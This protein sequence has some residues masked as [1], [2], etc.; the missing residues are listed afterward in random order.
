M[1]KILLI[2]LISCASISFAEAP[3]TND[4]AI[5]NVSEL[6]KTSVETLGV[7]LIALSYLINSDYQ[8]YMP[9]KYYKDKMKYYEELEKAGYISIEYVE[10][11]F[12][13]SPDPQ[14]MFQAIPTIKGG[15]IKVELNAP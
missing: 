7:S 10:R 1:N 2:L 13:D 3:K 4:E 14:K 15:S 6:N 5:N 12:P 9:V 11:V 8:S